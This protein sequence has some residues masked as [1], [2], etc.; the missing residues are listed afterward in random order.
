MRANARADM[1][2]ATFRVHLSLI[3]LY[4]TVWPDH[5]GKKSW[6]NFLVLVATIDENEG[7][8]RLSLA[9]GQTKSCHVWKIMV[10][11]EYIMQMIN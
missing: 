4:Y 11:S 10:W 5:V 9:S 3:R 7:H 8:L 1:L 2:W 6:S